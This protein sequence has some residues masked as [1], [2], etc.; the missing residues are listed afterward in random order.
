MVERN[1]GDA[2]MRGSVSSRRGLGPHHAHKDRVGSWDIS[3]LAAG[4][5]KVLRT[6]VRIGKARS[7]SR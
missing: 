2:A 1:M 7:R 5:D 6:A 4:T 3:C